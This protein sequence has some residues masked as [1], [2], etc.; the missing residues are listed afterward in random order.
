MCNACQIIGSNV[1]ADVD[2]HKEI[3]FDITFWGKFPSKALLQ[4]GK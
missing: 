3:V 4:E 2:I 1:G